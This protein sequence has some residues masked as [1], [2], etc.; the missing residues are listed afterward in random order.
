MAR[1][2]PGASLALLAVLLLA[3]SGARAAALSSG[4][5]LGFMATAMGVAQGFSATELLTLPPEGEGAGTDAGATACTVRTYGVFP[6]SFREEVRCGRSTRLTVLSGGRTVK[7]SD[8][9]V[10]DAEESPPDRVK[11]LL[12]FRSAEGLAARLGQSGVDL[13]TTSLGRLAGRIAW[14]VGARYPDESAPQLWVDRETWLPARWIVTRAGLDVRYEN[15][16]D[17]GA[18]GRPFLFPGRTAMFAGGRLIRER[19]LV[20]AQVDPPLP[21]DLFDVEAVQARCPA[22]DP[23]LPEDLD[24]TLEEVERILRD[25]RRLYR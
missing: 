20:A 14:V 22:P 25:F 4:E 17:L 2:L 12:L 11:D 15:W 6:G 9:A 5:I 13:G 23:P 18:P 21:P 16:T 3:A 1:R 7:V 19:V 10:E 24:S 8:G